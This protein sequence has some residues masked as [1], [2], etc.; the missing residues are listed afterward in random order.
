MKGHNDILCKTMRKRRPHWYS[1]QFKH[2]SHD[3]LDVLSWD[4]TM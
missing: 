3:I 4:L 2:G 1:E